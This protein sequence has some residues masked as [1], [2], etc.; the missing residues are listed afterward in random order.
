M[1]ATAEIGADGRARSASQFECQVD[2]D[3]PGQNDMSKPAVTAQFDEAQ[4]IFVC[5]SLL[6]Q[7]NR[8]NPAS[9]GL[10]LIA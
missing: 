6:N 2:R 10:V 1:I 8:G 4:F 5:D 7:G 3:L 9:Y